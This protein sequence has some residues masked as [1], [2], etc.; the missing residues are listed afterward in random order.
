MRAPGRALPRLLLLGLALLAWGA[1][2]RGAGCSGPGCGAAPR[3]GAGAGRSWEGARAAARARYTDLSDLLL[4]RHGGRG[5]PPGAGA[6]GGEAGG[7]AAHTCNPAAPAPAPAPLAGGA[8]C[9]VEGGGEQQAEQQR[10]EQRLEQQQ[11][12][13]Q[14]QQPDEQQQRQQQ[15]QQPARQQHWGAGAALLTHLAVFAAGWLAS[16]AR[17]HGAGPAVV[18]GAAAGAPA[19]PQP[20]TAGGGER[21]EPAPA[22]AAAKAARDD[23]A[24]APERCGGGSEGPA[25]SALRGDAPDHRPRKARPERLLLRR[26]R[27]GVAVQQARH[28]WGSRPGARAG[29]AWRRATGQ[30]DEW[31][32]DEQQPPQLALALQAAQQWPGQAVP[33]P[34]SSQARPVQVVITAQPDALHALVVPALRVLSR[35]S[36]ALEG[37]S[38]VAGSMVGVVARLHGGVEALVTRLDTA[39]GWAAAAQRAGAHAA[40]QALGERAAQLG[41]GL[42]ILGLAATAL[43]VGRLWEV[44]VV[45]VGA[46]QGATGAAAQQLAAAPHRHWRPRARLGL[47]QLLRAAARAVRCWSGGAVRAAPRQLAGPAGGRTGA[48][49]ARGGG[50]SRAWQLDVL[51]FRGVV[52][53]FAGAHVVHCLGG[54][55]LPWLALWLAWLGAQLALAVRP[56]GGAATGAAVAGVALVLPLAMAALPFHPAAILA[57]GVVLEAAP[58]LRALP[59]LRWLL[60]AGGAAA[61]PAAPAGGGAP[62]DQEASPWTDLPEPLML[63]VLSFLPPDLRAWAAKLVCKAARDRFRG[64]I[65]LR[66]PEL[67][68]AAVQEAWRAAPPLPWGEDVC[69]WAA[70]R[71]DVEMLRWARAQAEPAPWDTGVCSIAAECGRLEALRWLRASGCPWWRRECKH[72][73]AGNGHEA[74]VT[75]I[76]A[77]PAAPEEEPPGGA[78]SSPA[79]TRGCAGPTT[80]ARAAAALAAPQAAAAARRSSSWRRPA[81]AYGGPCTSCGRQH[82]LACTPE[83]AD[84]AERLMAAIQRHGRLD[85]DSPQPDPRFS[86]RM[87][88][89]HGPGRMLGVLVA[90]DR[91]GGRH[92]L[93]A[94]SGQITESW[95]IPGW[96]APVAGLTS[97]SPSYVRARRLIEAMSARLAACQAAR[98]GAQRARAAPQPRQE[99]E[100]Q[101][102]PR[103]E[104]QRGEE[105]A[106]PQPAAAAEEPSPAR[107]RWMAAQAAL[108]KGR[109]RRLSHALLEEVQRSYLTRDAGGR[110]LALLEAY[111]RAAERDGLPL[112]RAGAF[113]GMPAGVGDC[114][115]PKLLHAA[116]AEGWEPLGLA[117]VWC[118]SAPGTATPAKAGRAVPPVGLDPSA[119]REH[120]RLYGACFKCAAVLG[121]MLCD[122]GE[123]RGG[124]S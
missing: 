87:L 18:A 105:P 91:A 84:E 106:P 114:A 118:G 17:R 41:L 9:Q 26:R 13:A 1:A 42:Q 27:G 46:V 15:Q 55:W 67:P 66:C 104:Q 38:Q 101:A 16:A 75:W 76:L 20:A 3:G 59:S 99:Q 77:Q 7:A 61:P 64:A 37:A 53:S 113:L 86:L 58:A 21:A 70:A 60:P 83:A 2:P 48:R 110:D 100:P 35:L 68:L 6:E 63:H 119:S 71:G 11:Q 5:A 107:L 92:V 82:W 33:G 79:R 111:R 29:E 81:L 51:V 19:L 96:A 44:H 117:E 34:P 14:Q 98:G 45:R 109:R 30:Q 50:P 28:G 95:A 4:A 54:A 80:R 103:Q 12:Q 97:A 25:S 52:C 72:A 102:Q 123:G 56:L 122:G 115:A 73:A 10:L 90:R 23:G 89:S 88:T 8:C 124:A 31:E 32:E 22:A 108:L 40:Q 94:F 49:R 121:T 47:R 85:F 78:M 74:L 120:G 116:A 24:P 93:K 57:Q 39:L 62:S 36:A 112:T 65:S 69:F 43:R